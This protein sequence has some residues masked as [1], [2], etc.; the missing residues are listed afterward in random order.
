ML[1]MRGIAK[2]GNDSLD[3][4]VVCRKERERKKQPNNYLYYIHTSL[5]AELWWGG[6]KKKK[7]QKHEERG[8]NKRKSQETEIRIEQGGEEGQGWLLCRV[9]DCLI[10]GQDLREEKMR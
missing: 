3:S 6:F 7:K 8:R 1:E 10:K 9:G 5:I 2:T 4:S